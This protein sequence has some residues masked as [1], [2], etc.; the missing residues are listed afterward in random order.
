MDRY[1]AMATFVRVVET[2]SFSAA[3]RHLNVG[4]PAVSKTVAQLE[5]R[6]QVSLLIRS[7]H[8]LT[9]TE[10]GLR[11]YER[12]KAALREA[13]EAERDRVEAEGARVVKH[14][15]VLARY[16][17]YRGKGE[18]RRALVAER[19]R[20][21]GCAI[22][23]VNQVGGQDELVFDG[24]SF[25]VDAEGNSHW[26][27]RGGGPPVGLFANMKFAR[28]IYD[29]PKGSTVVIYTDGV[30]EAEDVH[31]EQFGTD[32]LNAVVCTHHQET[33][34]QIHAAIRR[35]LEEFIGERA[36]TDDSTLI[37]LKF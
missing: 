33:A 5:S 31:D 29:I 3:A 2:G 23:Y 21:A 1:Q 35:S 12:A 17:S 15:D 22:A 24:G 30:T 4:Q 16:G 14:P 34:E 10:A 11:F 8:G 27:E 37:V 13:D 20:E 26:L 28:E 18:A 25:V 9:P 36:P 6:L 7:T 19:A 32:R